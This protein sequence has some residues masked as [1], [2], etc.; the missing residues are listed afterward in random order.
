MPPPAPSPTRD[1]VD[2]VLGGQPWLP[3]RSSWTLGVIECD[4]H[5]DRVAVVAADVSGRAV[6]RAAYSRVYGPRA[7]LTLAVDRRLWH[8]GLAETLLLTLVDLAAA[9]G[10]ATLLASR[11]GLEDRTRA[12]LVERFGAR[13]TPAADPVDLEIATHL[14]SSPDRFT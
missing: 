5:G 2:R 4:P 10:I 7:E 11:R 8:P 9:R 14:R 3:R 13:E 1:V 6:G 12:L